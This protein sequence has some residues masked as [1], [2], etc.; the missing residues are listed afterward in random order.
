MPEKKQ[1]DAVNI[2]ITE[3][4]SRFPE[5]AEYVISPGEAL[6]AIHQALEDIKNYREDR[7]YIFR[8]IIGPL[9][10]DSIRKKFEKSFLNNL[11]IAYPSL[12]NAIGTFFSI[13]VLFKMEETNKNVRENYR[14]IV[15]PF[16]ELQFE[17]KIK[18]LEKDKPFGWKII[19]KFYQRNLDDISPLVNNLINLVALAWTFCPAIGEPEPETGYFNR[20]VFTSN[21]GFIDLGHFFN[22]AIIAY[23]YDEQEA[24]RRAEA[25]EFGQLQLREKN[26]LVKLRE[27][28]YLRLVTNILWGYATS[29]D[30]IEDRSSDKFG[31]ALGMDMRNERGNKLLMEYFIELY[32]QMLR[33]SFKVFKKQSKLQ[34]IIETITIFFKNLFYT[35][36]KSVTFDIEKYMKNFLDD[37]D[38]IDPDDRSVVPPELFKSTIDFYTEKYSSKDWK[39]YTCPDWHVVI[40]QDLWEQVVKQRKKFQQKLLPIKIQLKNGKQVDPYFEGNPNRA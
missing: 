35:L 23:L 14:F 26:W 6:K 8:T 12:I 11:S 4:E 1:D 40:P 37:Y 30:T 29:A 31:I 27:R 9:V 34:E 10:P 19:R 22:C 21:G 36:R 28:N 16:L 17:K 20:F 2:E 38:A 18:Q 7:L 25:T 33:K 3:V 39:E 24:E 5:K 32:T 13:P 15:L